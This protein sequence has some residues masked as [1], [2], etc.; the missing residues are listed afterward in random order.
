[1]L[2]NIRLC[3]N[4]RSPIN[5][6]V[7]C[8]ENIVRLYKCDILYRY[9]NL[10][11]FLNP[12]DR[13]RRSYLVIWKIQILDISSVICANRCKYLF[14]GNVIGQLLFHWQ[15]HFVDVSDFGR[16]TRQYY[17]NTV[18]ENV[19]IYRYYWKYN[20]IPSNNI[21]LKRCLSTMLKNCHYLN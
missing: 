8:D 7:C 15:F 14:M 1:M 9:E 20:I 3:Q 12:L 18:F 6:P 17:L 16:F 5:C 11:L 13:S 2:A 21:Y 4:I 10:L 19:C